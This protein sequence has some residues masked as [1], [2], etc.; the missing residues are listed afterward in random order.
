MLNS[1]FIKNKEYKYITN[2]LVTTIEDN[3]TYVF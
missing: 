1:A 3:A 2:A